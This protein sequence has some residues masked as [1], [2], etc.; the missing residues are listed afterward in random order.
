[1]GDKTDRFPGVC[2][3]TL[4]TFRSVRK[5]IGTIAGVTGNEHIAAQAAQQFHEHGIT[6]TG[7]AALSKKAGVSKRTLYERFGSKDGL[8]V[9]AYE[10]LDLPV[11]QMFTAAAEAAADTPR[12]Q[13]EAFFAQL[14]AMV[15]L[16]EFRGCPFSN[17]AAEL[18]DLDHPA[19][20]V[21]KRHKERIRRWILA[22]AKAAGAA[23]PAKLSRELMLVFAGAQSQAL[24]ERSSRPARE[25]KELAWALIAAAIESPRSTKTQTPALRGFK[26]G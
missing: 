18:S 11:F 3:G 5:P 26:S 17:A 12:G 1:L 23:D 6:A 7:V 14:E 4:Y 16:P 13:L 22:R 20:L 24:V 8:I 2:G 21:I 9:A 15:K 25:A 19:H 10:S